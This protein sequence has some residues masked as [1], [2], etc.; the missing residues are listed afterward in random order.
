FGISRILK[1]TSQSMRVAGTPAYMAPEGFDGKRNEQTDI[2]SA[3]IILYQLLNLRLP[4]PQTDQY[5]LMAAIFAKE[6]APFSDTVSLP[7]R[8]VTARAL[9]KDRRYRFQSVAEMQTALTAAYSSQTSQSKQKRKS[10]LSEIFES[11][12]R[13]QDF[14][15]QLGAAFEEIDIAAS[16]R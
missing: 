2:W 13:R 8:E 1:T 16:S 10:L 3:G 9:A 7:L 5:A 14:K 6:P 11:P 4:F 15:K 12:Q